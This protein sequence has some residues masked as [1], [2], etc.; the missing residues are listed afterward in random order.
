MPAS[1]NAPWPDV[2]PN[3]GPDLVSR[4]PD[5]VRGGAAKARQVSPTRARAHRARSILAGPEFEVCTPNWGSGA[6]HLAPDAPLSLHGL[7]KTEIRK[8][9]I[10][11][12]ASWPTLIVLR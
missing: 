9:L 7:K 4:R 10:F 6:V 1:G 11:R 12:V 3:V 8:H 2:L 5:D